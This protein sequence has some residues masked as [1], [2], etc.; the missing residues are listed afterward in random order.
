MA[1][2]NHADCPYQFHSSLILYA[3]VHRPLHPPVP[4]GETAYPGDMQMLRHRA[5][6]ERLI[7]TYLSPLDA[8]M[9]SKDLHNDDHFWPIDF[10]RVDTPDF[11]EQSGCLTVS[12]NYAYAA[13]RN[14]LVIGKGGNPVM[15]YTGD[16]FDIPQDERDHFH[17]GFSERVSDLINDVYV[18]AGL[19]NFADTLDAMDR[20]TREQIADAE[21]QAWER[22]PPTVR[23]SDLGKTSM[24]QCAIYDPESC[25]WLF[26]D[27]D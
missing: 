10:R 16:S 12:V 3:M 21:E 25:D 19:S 8:V 22:M 17:I 18:R 7:C 26:V 5:H 1:V 27:L 14:R 24:E 2:E 20:W 15:L 23:F 11:I 9:G 13:D 4:S 6:G